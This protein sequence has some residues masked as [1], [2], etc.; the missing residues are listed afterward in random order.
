MDFFGSNALAMKMNI[1]PDNKT[2]FT[3]DYV[4]FGAILGS[5]IIG[6]A[7]HGSPA[8]PLLPSRRLARGAAALARCE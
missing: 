8:R 2:A 3:G 7:Q 6:L 5:V 1:Q 4:G